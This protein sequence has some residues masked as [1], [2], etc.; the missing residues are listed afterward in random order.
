MLAW[1]SSDVGLPSATLVQHPPDNIL[2]PLVYLVAIDI[3]CRPTAGKTHFNVGSLFTTLIQ[4]FLVRKKTPSPVFTSH[5]SPRI[6][7]STASFSHTHWHPHRKRWA[8]VTDQH[9]F[10]ALCWLCLAITGLE[11]CWVSVS[12]RQWWYS[13]GN[14]CIA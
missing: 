7:H 13:D 14:L 12:V 8:S 5:I 3:T 9:W 11:Q 6:Y 1:L 2:M 4:L 10:D